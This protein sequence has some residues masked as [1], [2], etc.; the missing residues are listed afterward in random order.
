L[1]TPNPDIRHVYQIDISPEHVD[2]I[3]FSRRIYKTCLLNQH[4]DNS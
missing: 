2:K 3:D 1:G 4:I